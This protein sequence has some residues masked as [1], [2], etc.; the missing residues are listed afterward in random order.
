MPKGQLAW[1]T[2][3]GGN[4]DAVVGNFVDAPGGRAESEDFTDAR[5]EH[6]LL[7]ELADADRF[8]MFAG[9]KD[10]VK[11]AIRDGA[12]VENGKALCPLA[13]SEQIGVAIPGDARAKL[14]EFLGRVL[15]GEQ[16]EHAVK[17]GA[18]ERGEGCRAAN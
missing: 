7:V 17:C 13:R 6:H 2:W 15:A 10:T 5:F 1:L 8:L 18:G 9:Q 12:G 16:V 4:E 11:A 3:G 14:G